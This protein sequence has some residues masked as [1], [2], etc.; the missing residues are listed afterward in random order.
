MLRY[1]APASLTIGQMAPD[2][3]LRDLQGEMHALTDYR[4]RLVVVYFWSAECPSA[5]RADGLLAGWLPAWG[6]QV[7]LLPIASNANEEPDFMAQVAF[8]RDLQLVLR[9]AGQHVADDYHATHTP[10][11]FVINGS[12]RLVYQGGLDD[13][14]FRQRTPTRF[15]L[16]EAVEALLA[17]RS[18]DPAE[19]HPYGCT[20]VRFKPSTEED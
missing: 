12:G 14:T 5:A 6:D 16:R 4:A 2:F 11:F 18:P 20:I 1:D 15:F 13:T 17:G 19:T 7:A 9:D 10:H 3:T 8:E